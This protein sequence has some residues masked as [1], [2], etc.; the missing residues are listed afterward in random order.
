M[1]SNGCVEKKWILLAI[2]SSLSLK[3]QV[4]KVL[5]F[6]RRIQR[7]VQGDHLS[8]PGTP[9]A[10]LNQVNY[11]MEGGKDDNDKEEDEYDL[12]IH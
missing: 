2:S 10:D 6:D 11:T 4:W 7:F 9:A 5:D 12:L 1:S 3:C 8:R